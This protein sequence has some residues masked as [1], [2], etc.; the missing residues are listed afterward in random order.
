LSRYEDKKDLPLLMEIRKME[1]DFMAAG[2]DG[3][4]RD[5]VKKA[6]EWLDIAIAIL[7]A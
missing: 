3:A 5:S 2:K 7:P 6:M 4:Y 1:R